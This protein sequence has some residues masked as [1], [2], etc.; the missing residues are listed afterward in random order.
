MAFLETFDEDKEEKTPGAQILTGNGMNT[1]GQQQQAA[2][3]GTGYT[4][5]QAYLGNNQG[6]GKQIADAITQSTQSKINDLSGDKGAIASWKDTAKK[7]AD[8][9]TKKNAFGDVIASGSKKDIGNL[10]NNDAF[11]AWQQQAAYT[12]AQNAQN[13]SGYTNVRNSVKNTQE[14]VSG[15]GNYNGQKAALNQTYGQGG[16]YGTGFS[17]LDSLALRGDASGQQTLQN[18]Q[19]GAANIGDVFDQ[20]ANDV[21]QYLSGAKGRG[22]ANQKAAADAANTRYNTL[23]AQQQSAAQAAAAQQ[24]A[25]VEQQLQNQ[26]NATKNQSIIGALTPSEFISENSNYNPYSNASAEDVAALNALASLTGASPVVSGGDSNA[27]V[28][29]TAELSNTISQLKRILG[30]SEG[31]EVGPLGKTYEEARDE[32]FKN[33]YG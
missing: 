7:E 31:G 5:L 20:A 32:S 14:A 29:N 9:A 17:G 15:L 16:N 12:G 13:A 30:I 6:S 28:G 4:N 18:F 1:S 22:E 11:K 19:A 8:E 25:L 21:T 26:I 27:Y 10:G 33:I 2:N 3:T 23:A 24:R